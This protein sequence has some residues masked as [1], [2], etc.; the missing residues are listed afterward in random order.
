[1]AKLFSLLVVAPLNSVP[2]LMRFL[3]QI[4][5][6]FTF[7]ILKILTFDLPKRKFELVKTRPD[8]VFGVPRGRKCHALVQSGDDVYIIGGCRD[9]YGPRVCPEVFLFIS[10]VLHINRVDDPSIKSLMMFG[11]SI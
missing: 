11:A 1:M 10:N 5:L 8:P 3:F 9:L 2:N 7:R 4:A 6:N